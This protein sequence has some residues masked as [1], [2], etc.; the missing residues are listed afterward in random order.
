MAAFYLDAAFWVAVG[1]FM[2]LGVLAW[3][4]VHRIVVGA[5]DQRS[6]A[7]AAEFAEAKRLRD[8]AESLLGS[9][10][11]KRREAEAQ[12]ADIVANAKVEAERM[13]R[14]AEE[15]IADFVKRRTAQAEQKIAQ[16]ETQAAAEVRAAA[17][18]AAVRASETI[19]RARAAGDAGER[20]VREGLAGLKGRLN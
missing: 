13:A 20:F 5:L 15:R 10:E 14:E 18:D 7:I 11:A 9:Y 2:F 8:E 12:A 19:L 1:F 6:N 4:G 3:F 17:A 16:A